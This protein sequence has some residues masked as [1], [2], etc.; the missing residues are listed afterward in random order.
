MYLNLYSCIWQKTSKYFNLVSYKK[1]I[2]PFILDLK[3]QKSS[4]YSS[5]SWN[6]S[7]WIIIFIDNIKKPCTTF[8]STF[9]KY[10]LK[11]LLSKAWYP[12]RNSKCQKNRHVW[13][14]FR[15]SKCQKKTACLVPFRN[16]KCQKFGQQWYLS[17]ML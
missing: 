16:S 3:P 15:N 4:W 2:K 13:Y 12:F 5:A 9:A 10:C 14:P 6:I 8:Q 17:R 11:L 7:S 1:H